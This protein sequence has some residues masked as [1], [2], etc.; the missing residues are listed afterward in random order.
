MKNKIQLIGL[1]VL[2]FPVSVFC[3]DRNYDQELMDLLQGGKWFE[4][5]DYYEYNKENI[6][7]DLVLSSYNATTYKVLNKPE[8]AIEAYNLL[9][10]KYGNSIGSI[11][12]LLF[13]TSL[14]GCYK[15]VQ[16]Y[17]KVVAICD[18]IIYVYKTDTSLAS[19][20]ILDSAI[21]EV[22]E[23]KSFY[24]NLPTIT[25]INRKINRDISNQISFQNDKY[26]LTF[27][28][29]LNGH[30][31]TT[32]FDTGA[33]HLFM[34][35]YMADRIGIKIISSDTVLMNGYLGSAGMMGVLD[36]MEVAN[37]A[38]YNVP[39]FVNANK[40]SL[41][42]NK[43]EDENMIHIIDS[44]FNSFDVVLGMSA[45]KMLNSIEFDFEKKES[46]VW[47]RNYR[48]L[49]IFESG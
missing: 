3:Q 17:K 46:F 35:K 4:S 42:I 12:K 24:L 25:K 33:E 40:S 7:E 8:D 1:F 28:S 36:S 26:G 30:E 15:D 34:D 2:F 10:K 39:V 19:K 21:D 5:M 27:N 29:K 32:L 41:S 16:D 14:R 45:I 47:Y 44:A 48:F 13:L 38:L 31:V 11:G 37:I 43:I 20:E 9:L 18:S 22:K 23:Y 6:K 49:F